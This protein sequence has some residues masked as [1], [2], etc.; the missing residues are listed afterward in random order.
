MPLRVA[1]PFAFATSSSGLDLSVNVQSSLTFDVEGAKNRPV[2]KV[3]NVLK[4]MLTQLEKESKEDEDLY[5]TMT[6]WCETNDRE[7]TKAI[8]DAEA[9]IEDLG[10]KIEEHT[11]RSG[12]LGVEIKAHEK[13]VAQYQSAL[14][15]ATEIRMKELADFNGEEKDLLE[16]IS[17]LKSAVE[18]LSKHQG[19]FV[20]M[21]KAH[22]N[23]IAR[24][25]NVCVKKHSGL[26]QG[27]FTRTEKKA[28]TAFIENA[29]APSSDGSYAP[30]SGQIFGI[31]KQMLETFEQNLS[32]S[33]KNE[34]SKQASF[35]GVK[36]TKTTEIQAGQRQIDKKTQEL[37]VTD[38]KN[39]QAKQDIKD[40]K[41]SLS[42][43][44]QF[45]MMLKELCGKVD[46]EYETRTKERQAEMEACSKALAVL[47]SDEAHDM[48]TKTFNFMQVR[49]KIS[50]GRRARAADIL[51][52]AASKSKSHTLASLAQN[53]KIDAF[54]RVKKA[55]NDMIAALTQE[56]ADEIKHKDFCVEIQQESVEYRKENPREARTRCK[57]RGFG[58]EHSVILWRSQGFEGRDCGDGCPDE[59]CRRGP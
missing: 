11:A 31:L 26:L 51:L 56:K 6:C 47:T 40:T 34:M 12:K 52:K 8:S 58:H 32:D 16:S 39:A 57:D 25:L 54:E 42:A 4:D 35:D 19:S 41:A 29:A 55:I 48:F 33:Q 17:A 24:A 10:V 36:S 46:A 37:A 53:V 3:V 13:E 27:V 45:L 2:A 15:K 18:V 9:K 1:L 30:A 59:A 49:S 43:D 23:N 22:I 28:M 14:D 44:E 21:P 20:Q 50:S 7:K 38:E 5:E